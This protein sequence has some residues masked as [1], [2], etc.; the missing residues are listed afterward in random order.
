[1]SFFDCF[2]LKFWGLV[3][4]GIFFSTTNYDKKVNFLN[5]TSTNCCRFRYN[6]TDKG[7]VRFVRKISRPDPCHSIEHHRKWLNPTFQQLWSGRIGATTVWKSPF[8]IQMNKFQFCKYFICVFA[9]FCMGNDD[10]Q[11]VV[12]PKRPDHSCW[13]FGF[14]H[15]LRCSIEWQGSGLE[16]FFTNRTVPLWVLFNNVQCSTILEKSS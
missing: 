2:C 14:N 16:I 9:Q 13:N 4:P 6:F 1:M 10:F 8:P 11:M 3:W 12:A 7:T 15:F 5:P